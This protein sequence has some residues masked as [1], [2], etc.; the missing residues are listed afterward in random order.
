[1]DLNEEFSSRLVEPFKV[2]WLLMRRTDLAKIRREEIS[3]D[4]AIGICLDMVLAERTA[5]PKA[6]RLLHRA[7]DIHGYQK[8]K[9]FLS[10]R[11]ELV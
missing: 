5:Y 1:M 9:S 7:V 8:V 6:S 4:L 2:S 3:H 11:I 10:K